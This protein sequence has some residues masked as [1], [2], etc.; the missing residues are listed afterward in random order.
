MDRLESMDADRLLKQAL[1]ADC[2][3][4][5]PGN[6]AVI[7]S[8]ITTLCQRQMGTCPTV[9]NFPFH[10]HK[11]S[12]YSSLARGPL[13]GA[14]LTATSKW[15]MPLSHTSSRQTTDTS[16]WLN[17]RFEFLSLSLSLSQEA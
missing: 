16:G 12:M 9:D 2:L 8:Y 4:P 13:P 15:D 11:L 14:K 17:G 3:L 7:T 6:L 1:I 5:S 10:Q